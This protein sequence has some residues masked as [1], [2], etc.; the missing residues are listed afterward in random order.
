MEH[1]VFRVATLHDGWAVVV[2]GRGYLEDLKKAPEDTLS[3][4]Q[5]VDEVCI[6]RLRE[7]TSNHLQ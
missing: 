1:G 4:V 3:F 6:F 5:F 2:S 7:A